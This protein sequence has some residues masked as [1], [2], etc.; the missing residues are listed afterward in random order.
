MECYKSI[1]SSV[2][3]IHLLAWTCSQV[4]FKN[5]SYRSMLWYD[6]HTKFEYTYVFHNFG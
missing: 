1:R 3:E 2:V 6:S 5:E 4:Y